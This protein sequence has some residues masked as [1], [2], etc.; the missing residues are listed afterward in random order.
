MCQPSSFSA[1]ET[2]KAPQLEQS[3]LSSGHSS[4]H[5]L[6]FGVHSLVTIAR[7]HGPSLGPERMVVFFGLGP[8]AP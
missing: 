8:K 7:R 6:H 1:Q 2:Q 4:L 5:L 3:M